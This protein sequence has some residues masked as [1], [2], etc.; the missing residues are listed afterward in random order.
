[1]EDKIEVEIRKLLKQKVIVTSKAKTTSP[2]FEI[3]KEDG[4][5]RMVVDYRKLNS[6]AVDDF[7]PLPTIEYI[8]PSL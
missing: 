8:V 5:I 7:Y 3:M 4:N 2:A 1:M 6:I